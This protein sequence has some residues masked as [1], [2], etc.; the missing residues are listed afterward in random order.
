MKLLIPHSLLRSEYEPLREMVPFDILKKSARKCLEGL[1]N[2]IKTT[3]KI[4]GT[5]LKKVYI[6]APGGAAR[7]IFLLQVSASSAVFVMIRMKN[8]KQIGANMTVDNK[9]FKKI[10]E[11]NLEDVLNDL[12][13][14]QYDVFDLR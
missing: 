14:D 4:S 11:R 8:D 1:G 2:A 9:K 12:A 7:V 6:T 13:A 3:K 10:L 5:I